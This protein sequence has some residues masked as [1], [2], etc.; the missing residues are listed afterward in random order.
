MLGEVFPCNGPSPPPN[1][2]SADGK[3]TS[4]IATVR[5]S[6]E[7]CSGNLLRTT[8]HTSRYSEIARSDE[9]SCIKE[10]GWCVFV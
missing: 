6:G 8:L 3:A 9:S 4:I 5:R 10:P 1:E 2:A 7:T